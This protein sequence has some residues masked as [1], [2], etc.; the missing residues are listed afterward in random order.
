MSDDIVSFFSEFNTTA[1]ELFT[2]CDCGR[3]FAKI[4]HYEQAAAERQ[5]LSE[6]ENTIQSCPL[7]NGQPQSW[8]I[9]R[10]DQQRTRLICKTRERR[11]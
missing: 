8:V 4:S 3:L 7:C 6:M 1:Y 5:M 9:M 10:V 2:Y 11:D